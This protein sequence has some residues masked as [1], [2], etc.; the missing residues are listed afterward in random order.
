MKIVEVYVAQDDKQ[1]D[2]EETAKLWEAW[3]RVKE[4]LEDAL[5]PNDQ[6]WNGVLAFQARLYT[7]VKVLGKYGG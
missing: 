7:V 3:L 6:A 4:V 5:G 1:F 2:D